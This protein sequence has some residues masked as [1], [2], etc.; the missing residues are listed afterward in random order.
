MGYNT[1]NTEW[2]EVP[3]AQ[4]VRA[5]INLLFSTLDDS[6]KDAGPKLA[7]EVFAYDGM[8]IAAAGTA[9]GYAGKRR[10]GIFQSHPESSSC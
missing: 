8:L 10:A 9:S 2:P 4:D 6:S 5:L 7:D 1:V 3:I